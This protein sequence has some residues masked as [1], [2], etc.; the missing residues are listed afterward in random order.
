MTMPTMLNSETFKYH[1]KQ[2]YPKHGTWG[3]NAGIL[4]CLVGAQHQ[5]NT[6]GGMNE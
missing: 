4:G 1:M 2:G 3:K 6:L 5:T